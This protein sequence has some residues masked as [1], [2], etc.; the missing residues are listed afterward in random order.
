MR[1]KL[2]MTVI[3]MQVM[4]GFGAVLVV[5]LMNYLASAKTLEAVQRQ[6]RGGIELKGK[7]LTMNQALGLRDAVMD[8]AFND[9]SRVVERTVEGDPDML[10]GLFI[11]Q[12]QKVWVFAQS[13][14]AGKLV[15]DWHH[16]G[17]KTEKAA[18]PTPKVTDKLVAG[19]NV[20]EFSVPVTDE[21]EQVLGWL[22]YGM[23]DAPL[24]KALVEAKAGSHRLLVITVGLLVLV[25]LATAGFGAARA[26]SLARDVVKLAPTGSIPDPVAAQGEPP[27]GERKD[28]PSACA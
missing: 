12:E 6:T 4:T 8:N 7:G 10:Y 11:D 1:K 17:V 23:S 3:G 22:Y 19:Q 18:A 16:L 14:T 5:T 24:L 15:N 25:V 21:Q 20:L 28:F 27:T 26:A 9:V 2:V 13:S